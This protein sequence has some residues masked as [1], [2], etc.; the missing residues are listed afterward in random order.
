[1]TE[2]ARQVDDD[3][4][5]H[6]D[7]DDYETIIQEESAST[8][9]LPDVPVAKERKSNGHISTGRGR[10]RKSTGNGRIDEDDTDE[11]DM[12]EE[13]EYLPDMSDSDEDDEIPLQSS[14]S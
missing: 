1:M 14:G 10:G 5:E 4:P 11:S 8:R 12:S 9:V 3:K 6:D 13:E 7:C 2:S